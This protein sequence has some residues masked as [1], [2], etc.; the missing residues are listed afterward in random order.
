MSRNGPSAWGNAN[1]NGPPAFGNPPSF[2]T[3]V[4]SLL[5]T[6]DSRPDS[7]TTFPAIRDEEMSMHKTPLTELERENCILATE[8]RPLRPYICFCG[9]PADGAVL[10]WAHTAQDARKLA[11]PVIADWAD[12]G[13]ID[14]RARWLKM[15]PDY[16]QTLKLKD[17]P[18]VNAD[19]HM[20]PVCELWG[21]PPS[22]EGNGCWRCGGDGAA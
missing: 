5:E 6:V 17:V 2:P 22:L 12:C 14:V 13:F 3:Y 8:V 18:H 11:Y 7:A 16:M 4:A 19:P 20:C 9:E 15:H 1:R 10:A 21:N